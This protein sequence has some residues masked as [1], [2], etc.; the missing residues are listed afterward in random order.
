MPYNILFSSKQIG[1]VCVKN[2]LVMPAMGTG[3]AHTDGTVSDEM[4]AFYEERAKGG[5]GLIITEVTMVNPTG[6]H[7]P[8]Q[9]AAFDDSHIPGLTRL[10]ERV[11][12]YGCKIF[13]QLYHPGCQTFN[14]LVGGPL[15]TPSGIPRKS[16]P[17]Q[18]CRPMTQ[19]E[20]NNL[21]LDFAEA[22]ERAK[23][24][25]VDGVEIHAAHGY[26]LNQF[27]SP[28]SNKRT[29]EYGGDWKGRARIVQEIVTAI[30][31][32]V[33]RDYP[34]T[35]RM[36]VDEF[37]EMTDIPEPGLK[38][39]ES[40]K[41]LSWLVPFGFDAVSVSSGT[42]DT[43]NI[44]WEPSSYQPGWR[45]YL[46]KAVKKAVDVPVI[47]VSVLRDPDFAEQVLS[48]GDTADFVGVARG[49][50][51]DPEWGVKAMEGR[52]DEIRRCI[53]CLHCMEQLAFHNHTECAVNA[54]SHHEL[55]YGP[56]KQ[57]GAG[58]KVVVV[59][60][61]PSGLESARV[62][63]LRGF[64]PVL[65]EQEGELGGQLCYAAKPP[66]KEKINW[67]IQYYTRQLDLLGVEIRLNTRATVQAIQ[68]EQPYAVF[69]ATGSLPTIPRSIEGA[70]QD[71]VHSPLDILSG[72]VRPEGRTVVVVGSGMTGLETADLL[73]RWNNRVTVVEMQDTLGPDLY[74]QNRDDI[75]DR[76]KK[77]QVRLLPSRRLLAIGADRIRVMNLPEET[78]ETIDAQEVVLSLGVHADLSIHEEV[79]KAFP[80]AVLVGDAHCVGRIAGAV[81]S[82]YLAAAGLC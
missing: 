78:E 79:L 10:A 6:R 2:R 33:G 28:Y 4:I 58:R 41:M 7:N 67:L 40:L 47:A 16:M 3:L 37:M 22:A 18:E 1:T 27:L 61:G 49:Q 44:A 39:E 15:L 30:R 43:Q 52:A 54:R 20:I 53:S 75:L 65:F 36:S 5:A 66:M 60:S 19:Y 55:E 42:Y 31:E 81:R 34:V 56:L 59:G 12:Q 29:D 73:C 8:W 35:L 45:L 82:G 70:D 13:L 80:N 57:D 69:L 74:F 72:R 76:L 14:D 25:G 21:V 64:R 46:A 68:E 48:Q 38:L 24:A 62:L 17:P 26:L 71:H 11:H 32:R 51:A 63:A 50:L 77:Y 9:I 23:L